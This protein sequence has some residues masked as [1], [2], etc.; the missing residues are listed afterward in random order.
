MTETPVRQ[1]G[2]VDDRLWAAMQAVPEELGLSFTE[3]AVRTLITAGIDTLGHP[4]RRGGKKALLVLMQN[5]SWK[6]KKRGE[7]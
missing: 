3:W 6:P 1:L 7:R 2:R 5:R 4:N